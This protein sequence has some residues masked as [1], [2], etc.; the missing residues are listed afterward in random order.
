MRRQLAMVSLS[1]TALVMVAFLVPLALVVRNQA[2]DR[3]LSRAERDTQAIAASLAVAP[4]TMGA[5][6]SLD[7]AA[8]VLRA[9]RGESAFTVVFPDGR[10]VG[11]GFDESPGLPQARRGAAFSTDIEGGY[12]VLVPVLDT[13]DVPTP[14][15]VEPPIRTV[16]VRTVVSDQELQRG[17]ALAWVMLGALGVFLVVIA[18]VVTDRLGRKIVRPVAALSD[19]ARSLGRGDLETRVEPAGPPEVAEV[20]EAF[21][22]LAHR[23][24]GLLNAE[25]ESV[26]D[27]SHRLRTPLTALRLQAETLRDRDEAAALSADIDRV[28][29]AVDRMIEEARRPAESGVRSTADLAA[30]VRHRARYWKV[31]ADEQGRRTD[32]DTPESAQWVGIGSDELGAVIDTLIENVFAHTAP[33]VGYHI[34]VEPVDGG[35]ELVVE[36][37]GAG[38]PDTAV[39]RRGASAGGSTGLG[40]DIARRAAQRTG[41]DL[42]VTNRPEGGARVSVRFGALD[43]VEVGGGGAHLGA[44]AG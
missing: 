3:A 15:E 21:N 43:V 22:V 34:G 1:V 37:D 16:V 31:L 7:L 41:G 40:L 27:L 33:G 18:V 38:F 28:G 19:A 44:P 6:I 39:V 25:R 36:D 23:L 10:T 17:V 13:F 4:A 35:V 26:A 5:D 32:V 29:K 30:V 12:E 2:A 14:G 9:F 42:V 8:D 11:A 24:V 20:G